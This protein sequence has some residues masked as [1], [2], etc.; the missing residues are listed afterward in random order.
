LQLQHMRRQTSAVSLGTVL[1]ERSAERLLALAR[2]RLGQTTLTAPVLGLSISVPQLVPFT[3]DSQSFVPDPRSRAIGWTQLVD[4]LTARLGTEKIHKLRAVD[5]HRPEQA[6]AR[7]AATTLSIAPVPALKTPVPLWLLP[8]PRA[9]MSRDGSP[10]CRGQ[11]ALLA[12]PQRIEAGWWDGSSA[13]R[14]YYVARNPHGET[15]W[16]YREHR[17]EAPWYLHGIFA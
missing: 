13:C 1:P 17:R 14:D 5:D 15:L 9:L 12:G 11:L 4:K 16:I 10:L 6:W 7:C 8:I 2:E 3:E